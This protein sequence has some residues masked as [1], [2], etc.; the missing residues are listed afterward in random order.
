[1]KKLTPLFTLLLITLLTAFKA[2]NLPALFSNRLSR[3][4][5]TFTAPEGYK[6]V[7]VISNGQM[8]YE[9]AIKSRDK[10]FEVRYAVTPLDSIFIQ[11]KAMKNDTNL[12]HVTAVSPNKLYYASFLAAMANISGGGQPKVQAFPPAAVKHDFNADWGASSV[13]EVSGEFGKGYKYCMAVAI[14]KDNLADAYVFYLAD[15]LQD[16]Q[17]LMD[18]IFYNMKFK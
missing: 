16:I 12:V 6:E 8:H 9:Y 3:S 17:A 5:L 2:D 18:P 1:M 7:P 13:C 4:Q 10:N 14:H 11:I 15:N